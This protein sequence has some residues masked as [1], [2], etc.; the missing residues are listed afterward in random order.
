MRVF[1]QVVRTVL[2]GVVAGSACGV[3]ECGKTIIAQHTLLLRRGTHTARVDQFAIA[4]SDALVE[5]G[6][7]FVIKTSHEMVSVVAEEYRRRLV[8][9]VR[10]RGYPFD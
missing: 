5:L 2:L 4:A 7:S 10:N 8:A 1:H 6:V 9:F 3:L